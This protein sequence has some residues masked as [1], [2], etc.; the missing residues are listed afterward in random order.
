MARWAAQ[1]ATMGGSVIECRRLRPLGSGHRSLVERRG[2]LAHLQILLDRRAEPSH[3][4]LNESRQE[5][6]TAIH[7]RRQL[8]IRE[9][10]KNPANAPLIFPA[11]GS[12]MLVSSVGVADLAACCSASASLRFSSSRRCPASSASRRSTRI[13]SAAPVAPAPCA[14]ELRMN[15]CADRR[16]E[17]RREHD[18]TEQ[19]TH[20]GPNCIA[21]SPDVAAHLGTTSRHPTRPSS[22]ATVARPT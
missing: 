8:E 19:G 10:E 15:R 1:S 13:R 20:H 2:A 21:Q 6:V 11:V 4:Y 17:R 9:G 12:V 5:R 18:G 16:E 7:A 3:L 14:Y 22:S